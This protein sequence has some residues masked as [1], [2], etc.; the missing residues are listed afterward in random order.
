MFLLNLKA[1]YLNDAGNKP[2]LRHSEWLQSKVHDL[3]L[4]SPSRVTFIK[5]KSSVFAYISP[6]PVEWC[7]P[8]EEAESRLKLTYC[9]GSKTFAVHCSFIN[10]KPQVQHDNYLV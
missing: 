2:N 9:V 6:R 3:S 10:V 7:Q 8:C 5:S 1:S 4:E